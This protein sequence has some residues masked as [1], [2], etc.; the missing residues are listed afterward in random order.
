[1]NDPHKFII[2]ALFT[3]DIARHQAELDVI[4]PG[5]LC[6]AQADHSAAEIEALTTQVLAGL[7]PTSELALP[8]GV[9]LQVLSYSPS[10]DPL[11]GTVPLDVVVAP[12]AAQE[13]FDET[14]G[15]GV[16]VL[17]AQLRPVA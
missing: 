12:A 10:G 7:S 1:M 15:P 17:N 3:G 14:Y 6:V 9:T 4:W 16:V 8:N 2:V 5:A 13:Y 11:S